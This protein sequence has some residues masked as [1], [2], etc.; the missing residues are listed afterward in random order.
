MKWNLFSRRDN[1]H[2]ES[3]ALASWLLCCDR[4]YVRMHAA[5]SILIVKTVTDYNHCT[6]YYQLLSFNF[7]DTMDLFDC[8]SKRG[9][10]KLWQPAKQSRACCTVQ[11]GYYFKRTLKNW[12]GCGKIGNSQFAVLNSTESS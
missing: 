3:M 5:A 8:R 1:M 6:M 7:T 2:S 9:L 12:G 11:L 4:T 10:R